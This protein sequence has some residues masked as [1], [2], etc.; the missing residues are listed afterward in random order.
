MSRRVPEP[1]PCTECG[2]PTTREARRDVRRCAGCCAAR[3]K[4]LDRA[5][6]PPTGTARL[7][8]CGYCTRPTLARDEGGHAAC[9]EGYGCA[10]KRTVAPTVQHRKT[11]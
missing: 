10:A 2:T 3:T 11:G 1:V 8:A 6:H 4:R 7:L 5:R 9:G